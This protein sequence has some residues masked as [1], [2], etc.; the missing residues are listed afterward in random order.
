MLS[1]KLK[2]HFSRPQEP[3]K[4]TKIKLDTT[5]I[6]VFLSDG[7]IIYTPLD[8]F[9]ILK[10]AL[11]AADPLSREKYRISP[12]GIHWDELDEDIPIETF[13]DDYR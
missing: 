10:A 11:K 3:T 12:R 8:W 9:P 4:I 2:D 6:I 5:M 13:L 7:R 1:T